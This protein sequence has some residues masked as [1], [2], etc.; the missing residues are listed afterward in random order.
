MGCMG[1]W[2]RGPQ[3]RF[4]ALRPLADAASAV[5]APTTPNCMRSTQAPPG[6]GPLFPRPPQI[7]RE[8]ERAVVKDVRRGP[9]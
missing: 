6:V 1:A 8:G 5:P 2:G 7:Q 9:C 4:L 3:G